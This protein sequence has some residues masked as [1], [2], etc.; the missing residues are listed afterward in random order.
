M[1]SRSYSPKKVLREVSKEFLSRYWSER[2]LPPID[3]DDHTESEIANAAFEIFQSLDHLVRLE[4]DHDL[5]DIHQLA[6]EEGMSATIPELLDTHDDIVDTLLEMDNFYD[7]ATSVLLDRPKIF[8]LALHFVGLSSL[9]KRY[10]RKRRGVPAI[11]PRMSPKDLER[12]G[13]TLSQYLQLNEGRGRHCHVEA[14][15]SA[16]GYSFAAY[17]EDYGRT[18]LEYEQNSLVR[19]KVRPASDIDFLYQPEKG[20]L[21]I[22]AKGARKK[23]S[24]LQEIFGRSIL[25]VDLGY[26][27][28]VGKIYAL[29]RLKD[30]DFSFVFGHNSFIEAVEIKSVFVKDRDDGRASMLFPNAVSGAEGWSYMGKYFAITEEEAAQTEKYPAWFLDIQKATIQVRFRPLAGQRRGHSTTFPLTKNDCKLDYEGR[31]A[32]IRQMLVDSGLELPPAEGIAA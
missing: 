29:D 26:D 5:Q 30:P 8:R 23:I 21:D 18:S 19:R 12:L 10:W 13:A 32:I 7:V 28:S 25:G 17:P 4:I 15:K 22:Y 31:D 6:C 27:P 11:E 1:S 20:A 14:Y 2:D 24:D 3:F 9:N 16:Q